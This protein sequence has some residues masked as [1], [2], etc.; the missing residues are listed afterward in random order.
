MLGTEAIAV[1]GVI[2]SIISI[3]DGT[4]QVYD[5]ATNA[6]GLPE[7]FCE[8]A[9]RL[10]IVRNILASAKRHIGEEDTDE[11]SCKEV[12]DIVEGCGKKAKK[13]EEL[14]QKVISADGASRA[15]RYVSAARTL[16]KGSRVETLMKGILE[17]VQLLAINYSMTTVTDNQRKEVAEAIKEV[18][19]LPPSIPEHAIEGIGFTAIHS[20]SGSINQAQGDQYNNLGSGQIYYAQSMTFGSHGKN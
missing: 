19:A 11:D 6:Q 4:K 10:P 8:V 1:L 2:A 18:T 16:G 14:F 3:I 9:A 12:K 5:A 17:D 20:G 15:E 13:L 7:A